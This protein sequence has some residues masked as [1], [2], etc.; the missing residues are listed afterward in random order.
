MPLDDFMLRATLAAMGVAIAAAPLG[1]FVVWRRMAFFGDATAH[2]AVLGVAL[3]LA[4]SISIFV[5][6]L[7]VALIMA[8]MVS[9]LGRRGYA[10]DTLLGVLSHAA[11][12]LGLVA[13]SVVSDVRIDL[14]AYLFGDVLA[15]Q[16]VDLLVIWTGTVVV[17]SALAWRWS[18]LL[19]ATLNPDLACAAGIDPQREQTLLTIA[20][21]LV[22]A[23]AIKVVGV[24]LIAAM[25]IIPAAAARPFASTPERMV[26]VAAAIGAIAAVGGLH[27]SYALDTPPSPSIVSVAAGLFGASSVSVAT[28]RWL[29]RQ[30]GNALQARDR[31]ERLP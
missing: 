17:L 5:G 2:A 10:M 13:V 18:A 19:T 28:G 3:A 20:L 22:V 16:R 25:L 1:C 27:L 11:L 23:V 9:V 24:L 14:M 12:A 7:T 26:L 21:A 30:L 4:L 31:T 15:V 6:V 8:M 29:R